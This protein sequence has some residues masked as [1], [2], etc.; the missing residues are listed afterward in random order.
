[1][2]RAL[3]WD[4]DGT[5]LD[6]Q[7]AERAAIVSLFSEFGLGPC[8]EAMVR[9]YSAINDGFWKRLERGEITKPQVLVGRFE[10]FFAECGLDVSL[11]PAFNARYQLALGDTIVFR[12]DALNLVRELRGRVKQYVVSN[13][14]VA[15]QTKKLTLSG[16]GALMDGIFL[17]E[18]V[19]AEKPSSHFFDSVFAV[20]APVT[21]AEAM[22]VGDS[23]TSGILG[24][25]RAGLVTCW[26]NPHGASAPDRSLIDCEITDLRDVPALLG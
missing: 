7:A 15:A 4:V 20:L 12:D 11:A 6:F 24:G 26:Y 21:P 9:R 1:M 25:R 5:L 14:T 19:G 23:L 13:G 16:L 18:E 17:S 10:V 8:S 22:I 2:I 3:L